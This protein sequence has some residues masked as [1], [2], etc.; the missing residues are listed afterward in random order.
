MEKAVNSGSSSVLGDKSTETTPV[1][2]IRP[3]GG[4]I[5]IDFREIWAYRGLLY[6]FTWRDLK[7]RYRQTILGVAWAIIQPV[8][9]VIV[10][11]L[12]FGKLAK[13]PS[14]GV[15]YALFSFVAL[16]P[17]S[18][19][20]SGLGRATGSVLGGGGLI[21]KVYFPRLI[22]PL[23]S[24]ITPLV[25]FA[26]SFVV[27]IGLM[28]YFGVMPGIGIILL[29]AFL[30]LALMTAL[31]VGLWLSAIYVKY[32]DIGFLIGFLTQIW[33]YASPVVYPSSLVPEKFQIIYDLNPMTGVIEGFR[34]ALLGTPPPRA[35]T[36]GSVIMVIVILISGAYY[37]RRMEKTFAD[38][39]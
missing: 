3:P 10:F 20:A 16:L 13:I 18:L 21:R 33:F 29:P 34:W 22:L 12:I 24:I 8:F 26:I 15:P 28:F 38:V 32:R 2:V 5:K 23:A 35:M 25:D 27:L 9:M 14:E 11:T 39:T 4:W 17:W 36:A 37:F 30:V 19:F 6:V 7:V 1:T 31:G